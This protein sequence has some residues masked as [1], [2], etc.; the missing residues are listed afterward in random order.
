[1]KRRSF[2]IAHQMWGSKTCSVLNALHICLVASAAINWKSTKEAS[3]GSKMCC[4]E[5]MIEVRRSPQIEKSFE[6]SVI[7][8]LG[9]QLPS[10]EFI[11]GVCRVQLIQI[12]MSRKAVFV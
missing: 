11:S 7:N 3:T 2:D 5:G 9:H 6:E 4:G 12:R 10:F 1:M 8:E